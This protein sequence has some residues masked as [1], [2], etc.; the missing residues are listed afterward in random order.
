MT[1]RLKPPS[2]EHSAAP[3]ALARAQV[4]AGAMAAAVGVYA[5][6]AWLVVEVLEG[7]EGLIGGLPAPW[8]GVLIAVAAAMLLAAPVIE[9]R[10]AAG[11]G[12][13]ADV[14]ERYRL[15]KTVGF[16]IREAA[17]VVGLVVGITT[18]EPRWTW[19]VCAGTLVLMALAWPR[20]ADLP[21]RYSRD[22]R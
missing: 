4:L 16:A 1:T 13:A 14:P 2:E 11:G 9:R 18:G 17:A 21:S 20:A 15:A 7:G 22:P 12:E 10:V 19:A 6:V 3:D 8:P 5:L